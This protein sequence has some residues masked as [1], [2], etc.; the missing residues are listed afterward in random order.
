ME[1]RTVSLHS[2]SITD[3]ERAVVDDV[4]SSGQLKGGGTYDRRCGELLETAFDAPNALMTTSCTHALEMVALLLNIGPGD[5][6]VLPSYTFSS[7]ATAFLRQGATL[8]F[9]DI[10][11]ETLTIDPEQFAELVSTETVAVVPVHYAGVACEMDRLCA[12]AEEYDVAVV[13]DAAQAINASYDGDYLGTIGDFGCY[14]FHGTKSYVAGE[15]GALVISDNKDVERAEILRQKGTN[16]DQFRRGKIEKYEWVDTGSS[17]VPSEL[18]TALAFVQLERRDEIRAARE[19]VYDYYFDELAGLVA[20]GRVAVPTIPNPCKPNYHLF[21]LLVDSEA[22]RDA[23]VDHLR[24]RGVEAAQ[25]Y[26]PLHTARKGRELGY[27]AG[28]LPVTE[29]QATR[30]LRLPVHPNLTT[31]DCAYVVDAV[32]DFFD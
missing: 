15:G 11:P 31:D 7:T 29:R 5:E 6:V 2:P 14:S 23:L 9:C 12:I 26:E 30:L 28:D 1:P 18:Q 32:R 19:T 16:Y 25:H 4:V 24:D 20:N 13:E 3:R 17:Y 10:D 21:Y 8:T 27:E 22:E